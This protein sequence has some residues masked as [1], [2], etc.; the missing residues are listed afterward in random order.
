MHDIKFTILTTFKCNSVALS[1]FTLLCNHQHYPVPEPHTETLYPLSNNFPFFLLHGS[2]VTTIVLSVSINL[3][4]LST[5]FRQNHNIFTFVTGLFHVTS[6][7]QSSTML[8]YIRIS[9]IFKAEWA[10]VVAQL[11]SNMTA[12]QETWVQ[13]LGWEDPLEKGKATHSSILAWRIPCIVH[14]ITKSRT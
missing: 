9:F 10:S 14:G 8:Q 3:I 4:I 7:L 2:L 1:T 13:S 11:V 6:C 5:S 12:M